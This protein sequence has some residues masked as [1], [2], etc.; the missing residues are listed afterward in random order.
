MYNVVP[1]HPSFDTDKDAIQHVC[2]VYVYAL[3][4]TL[5]QVLS[6]GH[7][8]LGIRGQGVYCT[9]YAILWYINQIDVQNRMP[10]QLPQLNFSLAT[11]VRCCMFTA[12]IVAANGDVYQHI[13]WIEEDVFNQS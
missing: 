9:A 13:L 10:Q 3:P 5:L 2:C 8:M 12:C 1:H 6:L 11:F 4:T 7:T